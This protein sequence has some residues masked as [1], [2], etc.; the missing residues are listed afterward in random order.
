MKSHPWIYKLA[1]LALV[2]I[3][4]VIGTL[5][6]SNAPVASPTP[7]RVNPLNQVP[8]PVN[9][10]ARQV[11]ASLSEQN[12]EVRSGYFK[13][14]TKD[15]CDYSYEVME[16]CYGN[17]PAAPYVLPAL[18]VW[19]DE[20]KNPATKNAFGPTMEGY[21]VSYR[22]DPREAILIMGVLPPPAAYFGSQ[23]Y[24][25]NRRQASWN[26][27][28]PRYQQIVAKYP[29][30]LVNALFNYV[31]QDHARI[32]LA[33]SL[34]NAINNVV[35][36]QQSG[37]VWDQVR[38]IIITP[39]PY[40]DRTIREN[41]RK[42]A[43][44]PADI[45]TEPIPD[46]MLTGLDMDAD[47]FLTL[48]RYS[49]PNPENKAAAET[50]QQQLPLVLLRIRD[51]TPDRPAEKFPA[52]TEPEARVSAVPSERLLGNSVKNLLLA[53]MKQWGAACAQPD[54][55]D[56]IEPFQNWQTP[57]ISLVGP[58]CQEIGM[59]CLGDTQDTIYQ[60]SS[61]MPLDNHEVYAVAGPLGTITGNATYV[62]LG[63]N[64]SLKKKG[65][66]NLSQSDLEGTAS[67]YASSVVT[68]TEQLYLYYFA[69]NCAGLEAL[70]GGNCRSISE[71][72]VPVCSNPAD[73]PCDGLSFSLRDYIL[74]GTRRGPDAAGTLPPVLLK[75]S[76]PT[77][78]IDLRTVYLAF[79]WNSHRLGFR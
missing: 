51:T 34:S 9:T 49:M 62:G 48:I 79:G 20:A 37:A 77:G 65:F 13:L 69:R 17:N 38:Y 68:S 10:I 11:M 27:S 15:D 2:V 57:I 53:V 47:E 14:Y 60:I 4:L 8:E 21:D 25:S 3:L 33:A 45:F 29:P 59:N 52:F 28:D 32:Q 16:T 43:I 23:T 19:P 46:G 72:D 30:S 76:R 58:R 74:P 78:L 64:S 44:A 42:S 26:T 18:P 70:T 24:L 12:F 67:A 61:A 56:R 54:C 6:C 75:L 50:W 36:T 39:D 40:M 31:P 55:S 5:G 41:L 7:E 63:L 1:I 35:I 22:L 73:S 71:I 66:D